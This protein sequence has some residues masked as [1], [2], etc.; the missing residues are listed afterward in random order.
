MS[1]YRNGRICGDV[2]WS[3]K[4]FEDPAP[5]NMADEGTGTVDVRGVSRPAG[6]LDTKMGRERTDSAGVDCWK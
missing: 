1:Y 6:E 2:S 3:L 4:C 5:I